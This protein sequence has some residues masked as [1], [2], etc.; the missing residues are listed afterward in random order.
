[1]K[2]RYLYLKQLFE[3]AGDGGN[4]GAGGDGGTGGAGGT[5]AGDN[6]GTGDDGKGGEGGKSHQC[7]RYCPL[8]GGSG[9]GR[10]APLPH[11]LRSPHPPGGAGDG[12]LPAV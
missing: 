4:G 11:L 5:G 1:M 2:R 6:G 12:Q 7:G 10:G 8:R 9:H 3:G